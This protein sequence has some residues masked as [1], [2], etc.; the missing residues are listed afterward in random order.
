MGREQPHEGEADQGKDVL[1]KERNNWGRRMRGLHRRERPKLR[2]K[3]QEEVE[4]GVTLWDKRKQVVFQ[5]KEEKFF[6]SKHDIL[7]SFGHFSLDPPAAVFPGG[8]TL[9]RGSTASAKYEAMYAEH[10][11]GR[12]PLAALWGVNYLTPGQ[13]VTQGSGAQQKRH[14][15]G[16]TR[17][18]I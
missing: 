4:K 14:R 15:L 12:R 5:F 18:W 9:S 7:W 16:G 10:R 6:F 11:P 13:G 17:I 1:Q 3:Q 2:L 8:L